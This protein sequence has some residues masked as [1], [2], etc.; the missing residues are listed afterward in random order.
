MKNAIYVGKPQFVTFG[1]RFPESSGTDLDYGVTG[2]L[3]DD[4]FPPV[5]MKDGRNIAITLEPGDRALFYIPA[6]DMRRHCPA[7]R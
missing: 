3:N 4:C 2:R 1:P 7:P 6:E 5:F